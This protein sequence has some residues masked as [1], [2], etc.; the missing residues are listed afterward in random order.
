ME[1]TVGIFLVLMAMAFVCAF[2][3]SS[4]G[5]GYGTILGPL[6]LIMG[7]SPTV[8]VPAILLTQAFEGF[9]ASM[10]HQQFENVSFEPS[11]REWK[12]LIMVVGFGI[13]AAV[14]AAVIAVNIPKVVLKTYIG[15]LVT[16]MGIILLTRKSF[17]FTWNRMVFVGILSAFNK[18]MTGGGFGPVITGGQVMAGQEHK[19]AVGITTMAQA[20]ICISGF[21]AYMIFRTVRE[22]PG[23]VLEMRLADFFTRMFSPQLFQWELILALFI[24][25]IMVAPFGAF[26]TRSLKQVSIH[27]MMG[28]L[29]TVLGIWTLARTWFF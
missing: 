11:S 4:M 14:M 27:Y 15:L 20:P 17:T 1:I 7:F 29:I 24:G 9:V 26:T 2:I 8:V 5:M 10:F 19:A 22:V 16:A 6:L 13:V 18:G 25:S 3:D 28:G 12:M 21:F 23:A